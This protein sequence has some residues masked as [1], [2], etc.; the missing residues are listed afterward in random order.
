LETGIPALYVCSVPLVMTTIVHLLK[1]S[2]MPTS[3]IIKKKK[4]PG[5]LAAAAEF[6]EAARGGRVLRSA[7]YKLW[8]DLS[9]RRHSSR[10]AGKMLQV[11][12]SDPIHGRGL[13][14]VAD[15]D[16]TYLEGFDFSIQCQ[17][18]RCLYVPVETD[19]DRAT[20]QC[21]FKLPTFT[22]QSAMTISG[23]LTHVE[24]I[25]S[26][27]AINF[28]RESFVSKT[29]KSDL[30]PINE[31]MELL[32]QPLLPAASGSPIILVFGVQFYYVINGRPYSVCDRTVSSLCIVKVQPPPL[33]LPLQ[34]AAS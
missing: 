34:K 9:D 6:S 22:P 28:D 13:R 25:A 3:K 7:F 20:G 4:A 8:K 24:F 14:T 15:G 10:M 21:T 19:I 30:F 5:M 18:S 27:A 2:V 23:N 29:V 1:L 33:S 12:Q 11:V 26:A 31:P 32:L 17:L 16:L